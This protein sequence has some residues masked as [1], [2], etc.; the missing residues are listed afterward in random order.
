MKTFKVSFL[1]IVNKKNIIVGIYYVRETI[2]VKFKNIKLT[3]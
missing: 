1:K 2:S 3:K